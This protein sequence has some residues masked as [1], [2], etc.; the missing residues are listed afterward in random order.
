MVTKRC[1]ICE[2]GVLKDLGTELGES[3]QGPG[4]RILETYSCGHEIA[5]QPLATADPERLKVER[6]TSSDATDPVPREGEAS[7]E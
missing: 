6:R 3:D 4:S 1:P 5:E 2:E 7:R